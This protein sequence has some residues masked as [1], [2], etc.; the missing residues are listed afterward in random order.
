MVRVKVNEAWRPDIFAMLSS[1]FTGTN[2]RAPAP[3]DPLDSSIFPVS[4]ALL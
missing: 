4:D 3:V 1:T 2:D